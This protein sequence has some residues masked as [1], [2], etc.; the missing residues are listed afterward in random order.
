MYN[1][2]YINCEVI[3]MLFRKKIE[4]SCNYCTR[5]AKLAD[6][7][8]LCSKKGIVAAD[9]KCFSFRYDPFKR[10]PVKPKALD[11]AKYNKEDFSL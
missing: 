1:I 2:V 9:G 7:Q 8:I 10:I 5:S 11:F 6:G 3:C 4:P